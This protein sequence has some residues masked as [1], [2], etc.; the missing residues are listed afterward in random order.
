M[1]FNE[2]EW[3]WLSMFGFLDCM[4]YEW[5]NCPIGWAGQYLD[6]DHVKNII[7]EVICE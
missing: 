7:L 2:K 3:G 6:K 4:H 1:A 5:K